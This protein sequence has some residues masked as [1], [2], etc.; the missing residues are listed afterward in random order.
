[1]HRAET[2]SDAATDTDGTHDPSDLWPTGYDFGPAVRPPDAVLHAAELFH[3]AYAEYL[4]AEA[5]RL[6]HLEAGV[7][8]AL[9]HDVAGV[10]EEAAEI[11]ERSAEWHRQ[12]PPLPTY[13][14]TKE[15]SNRYSPAKPSTDA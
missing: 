15:W 9:G 1:M 13:P 2:K 11:L 6:K 12:H 5:L 14:S 3:R 10:F 7:V 8:Q 4:E